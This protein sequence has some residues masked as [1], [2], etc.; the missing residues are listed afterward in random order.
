[1]GFLSF[2][3]LMWCITLMDLHVLNH[4]DPGMNPVPF[5]QEVIMLSGVIQTEKDQNCILICGIKKIIQR[6][7][8]IKEKQT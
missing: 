7:L 5:L 6:S 8:F 2:L 1:M 4:C 3:L